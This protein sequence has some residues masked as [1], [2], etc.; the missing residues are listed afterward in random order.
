M[1]LIGT[2]IHKAAKILSEG[3]LVA[4]PTETVYGLAANA[5]N[6]KAITSIFKA[7]K[8]PSFD[9]LIT[10]ISDINQLNTLTRKI[11]K[12][13]TALIQKFWPGPLTIVL[14]KTDKI[15]DLITSGLDNAAFRIPNHPITNALLECIP[16]PL[17]APSAN[18]F[19]YVSPTTAKH[20]EAQLGNKV[21]YILDGGPC[22]I[23]L[24]STIVSFKN[25]TPKILRLGGLSAEDIEQVIGKIDIQLHSSSKPEAP[26]MLTSHYSPGVEL[27]IG[28]IEELIKENNTKKIGIISY[29]KAFPNYINSVLAP[30]GN[31]SEAA[32][33]LFKF[34]RW[35]GNQPI[36]IILTEHVPNQGL[37]KA[38]NDRLNRAS[39]QV[40]NTA[41][42]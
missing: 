42:K 26:G 2:D 24:E 22:T 3:G 10:H 23:G 12:K 15:S 41:S 19:T 32:Q 14:P 30:S 11:P 6:D 35:M 36:E 8:R 18:P 40:A 13:A 34:L 20:V 27:K 1:S 17:V 29:K 28:N 7:K 38:I 31:L 9:P 25:N 33:N 4:I 39:H 21:D 5:Y 16:F 37:G